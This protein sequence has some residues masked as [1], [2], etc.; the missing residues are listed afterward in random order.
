MMSGFGPILA[1]P[2]AAKYDPTKHV[3]YELGMVL[4]ADDLPVGAMIR[5]GYDPDALVALAD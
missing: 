3:N 1:H 5:L 2:S 4:G